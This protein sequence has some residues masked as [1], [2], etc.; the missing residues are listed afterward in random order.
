[1]LKEGTGTSIKSIGFFKFT[2]RHL[3]HHT[4]SH[5]NCTSD[6]SAA[7]QTTKNLS[8]EVKKVPSAL[9]HSLCN[10]CNLSKI[11]RTGQCLQKPKKHYSSLDGS[12]KKRQESDG[13]L[14]N[15]F[16]TWTILLQSTS[17]PFVHCIIDG[18]RLVPLT[19]RML[20]IGLFRDLLKNKCINLPSLQFQILQPFWMFFL[21]CNLLRRSL[22]VTIMTENY[23]IIYNSDKLAEI[24]V[25]TYFISW[26]KVKTTSNIKFTNL[27]KHPFCILR[28]SKAVICL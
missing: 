15:R 27:Q 11:I 23:N 17:N 28:T 13:I 3:L 8:Q 1:M 4:T 22:L 7:P 25:T 19:E 5:H 26:N 10:N 24:F 2:Q 12:K 14:I 16:H 18:I 6:V 21:I 9:L 20:L